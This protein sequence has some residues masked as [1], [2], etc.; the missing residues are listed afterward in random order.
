M[1]AWTQQLHRDGENRQLSILDRPG[2]PSDTDNV[3]SLQ[4][5]V[6]LVKGLFR[7][8]GRKGRHDLNFG[9]VASNVIEVE[10]SLT[11]GH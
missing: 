5:L 6:Y 10:L 8:V 7:F 4:S 9:A 3:P 11:G 1:Q 2:C